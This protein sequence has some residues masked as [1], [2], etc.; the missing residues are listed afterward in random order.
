[1]KVTKSQLKQIIKE[2]ITDQ[3]DNRDKIAMSGMAE[4]LPDAAVAKIDQIKEIINSA[5]SMRMSW[6]LKAPDVLK[7]ITAVISAEPSAPAHA[8]ATAD[9]PSGQTVHAKTRPGE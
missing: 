7:K 2:A 4:P 3:W 6:V 5:D 1:M 8:G 9:L